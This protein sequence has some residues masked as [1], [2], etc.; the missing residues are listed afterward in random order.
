MTTLSYVD[1]EMAV[2][3]WAREHTG[4]VAVVGHRTFF[5]LPHDYQPATKGSALTLSLVGGAPD[6]YTP[7]DLPQILFSCWGETKA[8]AAA[9]RK[10]L[11]SA[12]HSL[13]RETVT[14][15]EVDVVLA[16]A[17]VTGNLY[18]PDTSGDPIFPRYIVTAA[19]AVLP[20][21]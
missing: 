19:V 8:D 12:L 6:P 13:S 18:R 3:T 5:S 7:L 2:R 15:D 21:S 1:P 10:A 11:I 9:V 14:V 20:S 16:D 17:R 4:L